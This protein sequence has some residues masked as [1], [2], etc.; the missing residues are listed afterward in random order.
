MNTKSPNN[1]QTQSTKTQPT[2]TQEATMKPQPLAP[3]DI[4]E[5][6]HLAR[7]AHAWVMSPSHIPHIHDALLK[8]G[9]IATGH[10][11]DLHDFDPD[12]KDAHE[13]ID[14]YKPTD[15][16]AMENMLKI[17]KYDIIVVPNQN[18][19]KPPKIYSAV[20]SAMG[21]DIAIPNHNHHSEDIGLVVQVEPYESQIFID[22]YEW[23]DRDQTDATNRVWGAGA[24][25]FDRESWDK[26]WGTFENWLHH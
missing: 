12:R 16:H 15:A 19:K 1:T 9:Y 21:I 18:P 17:K 25:E 23:I 22:N 8:E 20:G 6:S 13:I 5:H 7:V 2:E 4:I 26:A 11:V 10:G 3:L 24:F 14:N